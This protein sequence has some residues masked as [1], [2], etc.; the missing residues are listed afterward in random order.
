M[1]FVLHLPRPA[2]SAALWALP[3][4]GSLAC[5]PNPAITHWGG[6]GDT[7]TAPAFSS[8]AGESFRVVTVAEGLEHPWSMAFLPDGGMLVTERPGRLRLVREGRLD[9]TPIAGVPEV[10]AR[11]QG[12]LLEVS[13]HPDFETNRW[14]YLTF[15]KP[16]PDD[17]ATTALLRG[18]LDLDGMRLEEAE[19]LFTAD[20]WTGRG[21]HFGS[22]LA[23]APDGTLFMSVGDR[24]VQDEAQN[25]SNHQGTILRLNPDGSVPA[26]N[27]FV[28]RE[29]VR[30]E[31]Y[32][33][34]IRSP[35]GLFVHPETGALWETEHG[36]RGGD[37]LNVILPGR[38]YGWPSITYGINYIGTTITD[39]TARP[40]MEQPVHYWV[41][42]IAT[43]GLVIYTGDRFP[44]WRGSAFTGGLAGTQLARIALD[45]E[46]STGWETLLAE[47]QL[48][49][50]DVR[51]GPD[52]YLYLAV[53]LN[54]A[55]ILRLEPAGP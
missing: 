27:P 54:P 53:D 48:R 13:L 32:A 11:G 17:R 52:G 10:W 22:R 47:M 39:E 2:R 38:N 3:A 40:G 15:S 37:E 8:S 41:P 43:S 4:L 36:P 51:Q 5:A 35:Q 6:V 55:P 21:V 33:W 20:A 19:E 1:K 7:L 14:V 16:G 24:G 46:V 42:S 34:G 30:P 26:D 18:R 45:G 25:P 12:G 44:A 9:P 49:I 50:R 23:W 31:I 28:G 29:D